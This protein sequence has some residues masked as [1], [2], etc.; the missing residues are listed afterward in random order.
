MPRGNSNGMTSKRALSF[1][2]GN[3]QILKAQ[4]V[5]AKRGVT[6]FGSVEKLETLIAATEYAIAALKTYVASGK[7]A[8]KAAAR[9]PS[10]SGVS[11]PVI[12]ETG[13]DFTDDEYA[14]EP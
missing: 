6:T 1:A 9:L 7:S 11:A 3:L 13:S 2:T 4:L 8:L 10:A 14:D 5:Q 12:E